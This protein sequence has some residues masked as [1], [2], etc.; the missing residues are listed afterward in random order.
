MGGEVVQ[1][2]VVVGNDL[3]KVVK[4]QFLDGDWV[5]FSKNMT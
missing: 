4:V 3:M 1:K 2:V 5:G